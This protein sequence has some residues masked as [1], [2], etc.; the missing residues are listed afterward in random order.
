M[1]RMTIYSALASAVLS[2]S[3]TSASANT[4]VTIAASDFSTDLDGWSTS[5]GDQWTLSFSATGGNPNGYARGADGLGEPSYFLAPPKFLG[6]W[7]ALDVVPGNLVTS[8]LSWDAISIALGPTPTPLSSYPLAKISGPG[9]SAIV[10]SGLNVLPFEGQWRHQSI[11]IMLGPWTL[12]SGTWLG[13]LANV[14]SVQIS[15]EVVSNGSGPGVEIWGLDNVRLTTVVPE[16]PTTFLTI[17][18]LL[19]FFLREGIYHTAAAK[20]M[21]TTSSP[22]SCSGRRLRAGTS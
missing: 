7:T 8:S 19:F 22:H 6:N 1:Q 9:G 15:A 18:G 13:L 11:P 3:V 21:R 12:Q 4:E 14:T 20:F 2:L 17:L 16:L 5:P 10:E